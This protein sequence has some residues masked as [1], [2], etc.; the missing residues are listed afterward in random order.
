MR[1]HEGTFT[2]ADG[3]TIFHQHWLP[4]GDPAA[5]ILLFHGLGEH[6][7]RYVHVAGMLVDAGYAVHALD[8]RGH[9]RSEG[10]RT[11]VKTYDELQ[12]DLV[13]FRRLA[14]QQHPGLPVI[15]LGHS[16]GGNLAM[17]HVLDHQAGLRGLALSGAALQTVDAI[18]PLQKKV[19][20]V[21][22][23]VAP[24]VR[25]QGLSA[26]AV[27]RDPAVVAAY[28]NDPLVFHGKISAGLGVA[29]IDSMDRFR[30]RYT[31]LRLPLLIMHG[32]ADGLVPASS[33]HMLEAAAVNA[34]VTAHY[35]DGLFHEIFNEPEQ[36]HVFA[37]VRAWLTAVLA[38]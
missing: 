26:A 35:Y 14:E 5:V 9:G 4:D 10:K 24:G 31:E 36:Q 15:V 8:H 27:S 30:S 18:S 20:G 3:L 38:E 37:D 21:L 1:H 32:T 16:M 34:D 13:Q 7:N 22:A 17:G 25:P 28:E 11:F 29:L 19:F 6:S 12:R 2:A 23:K 33:S